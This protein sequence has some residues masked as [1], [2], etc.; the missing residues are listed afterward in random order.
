M[1]NQAL[2]P[3]HSPS[4]D[5]RLNRISRE[6]ISAQVLRDYLA[7]Q[8]A[9][10]EDTARYGLKR[11]AVDLGIMKDGSRI[12]DVEWHTITA[13]DFTELLYLWSEKEKRQ[14][15]GKDELAASSMKRY[16][17]ALRGLSRV[18]FTNGTMTG[19]QY[20]HIK[21]V[22]FPKG[23]NNAGRGMRVD[24]S[25]QKQLLDC[26][27]EDDRVQGLRDAAMLAILFGTGI[28]RAE[29]ASLKDSDFDILTGEFKV[30]VKGGNIENGFTSAWALPYIQQWL[31]LKA[32]YGMAGGHIL[33]RVLRGGKIT[34][35]GLTGQGVWYLFQQR[36]MMAGLP[37]KVAPHD[38]RRTM[39]TEMIEEYGELVAQRV[40]RHKSLDTTRIYD[41]RGDDLVKNIMAGRK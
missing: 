24:R 36:S 17:S 3:I 23:A 9:A 20:S 35:N 40:L 31:E 41:K 30:V 14:K 10:S 34:P 32:A 38:A 7:H 21:E 33:R 25:Y 1:D 39:A 28:R 37:F 6:G 5:I 22:K 4:R 13:S 27:M 12:E 11:I 16:L 19:D 8:T 15:K 26:C 29:A 2:A 18:C